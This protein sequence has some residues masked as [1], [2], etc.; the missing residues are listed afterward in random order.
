[1]RH[2]LSRG[3]RGPGRAGYDFV[4]AVEREAGAFEVRGTWPMESSSMRL[5]GV[6][7]LEES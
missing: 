1:M 5:S 6:A 3:S 4:V 2:A 7:L